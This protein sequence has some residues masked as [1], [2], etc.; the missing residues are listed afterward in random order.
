MVV[1]M[2]V[3]T[4]TSDRDEWQT[5]SDRIRIHDDPPAALIASIAWDAGDGNVTQVNLW[6]NPGAIADFFMERAVKVIQEMGEPSS[7]PHRHGE[8]VAVFIRGQ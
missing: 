1:R 2:F 4:I 8:P 6:D 3:E 5:W 7:K